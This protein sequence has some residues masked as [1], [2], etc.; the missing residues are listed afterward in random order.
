MLRVIRASAS[1]CANHRSSIT[2][3]P[4]SAESPVTGGSSVTPAVAGRDGGLPRNYREHPV[5]H[6]LADRR[7]GVG[8][9]GPRPLV[10]LVAVGGVG[11]RATRSPADGVDSGL[12]VAG[13]AIPVHLDLG[14]SPTAR[15]RCGGAAGRVRSSR[16][17]FSSLTSSASSGCCRS[18]WACW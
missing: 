3:G 7:A 13:A 4:T 6:R 18:A 15:G 11:R 2:A 17:A 5:I 8:T 9:S 16:L 10:H 14:P 1:G 12:V